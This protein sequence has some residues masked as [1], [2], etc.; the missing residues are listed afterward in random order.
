M[1]VLLKRAEEKEATCVRDTSINF[2]RLTIKVH[3]VFTSS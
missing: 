2:L 1:I 3:D